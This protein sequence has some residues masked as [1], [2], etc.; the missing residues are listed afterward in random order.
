MLLKRSE[1]VGRK[2][3]DDIKWDEDERKFTGVRKQ[4]ADSA[5]YEEYK[6]AKIEEDDSSD[7][8]DMVLN[9]NSSVSEAGKA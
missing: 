8:D 4:S 1:T 9:G 3:I 7:E 2:S 5:H 6:P